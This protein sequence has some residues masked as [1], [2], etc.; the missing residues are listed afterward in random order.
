ML[1]EKWS[2]TKIVGNLHIMF[3]NECAV[4]IK[5]L[6]KLVLL[7]KCPCNEYSHR[8]F[9]KSDKHARCFDILLKKI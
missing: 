4:R 1:L 8:D 9:K 2:A 5:C 3:K 7:K 6:Y